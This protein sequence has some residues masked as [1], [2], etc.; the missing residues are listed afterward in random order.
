MPAVSAVSLEKVAFTFA[1]VYNCGRSFHPVNWPP[2]GLTSLAVDIC[3]IHSSMTPSCCDSGID[4]ASLGGRESI[5]QS[6]Q[7]RHDVG[8][9]QVRLGDDSEEGVVLE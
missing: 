3:R 1:D 8:S 7:A 9:W 6:R 2:A 4:K 5:V